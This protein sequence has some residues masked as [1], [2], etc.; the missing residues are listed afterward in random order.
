MPIWDNIGGVY[1]KAKPYSNIGGVWVPDKKI[2]DNIAGV[3]RQGYTREI[4][5]TYEVHTTNG[6]HGEAHIVEV[7]SDYSVKYLTHGTDG[8]YYVDTFDVLFTFADPVRLPASNSIL[9]ESWYNNIA[10]MMQELYLDINGTQIASKGQYHYDSDNPTLGSKCIQA[11]N[12]GSEI[13]VS[14]LRYR[15]VSDRVLGG[16]T[17]REKI[18][19]YP[20]GGNPFTVT[21]S[22]ISTQ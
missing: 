12:L 5:W 18:T 6:S 16:A 13:N 8:D 17:G 11:I 9:W 21:N 1:H 10:S 7:L 14:T 2:Y 4:R 3:W 19:L 15:C 22:G 20:V